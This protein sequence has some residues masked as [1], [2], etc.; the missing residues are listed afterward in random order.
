MS[1]YRQVWLSILSSMLLALIASLFV[2]LYNGRTYL[3]TQL[4]LKNRDNAAALALA[5]GQEYTTPDDLV[6]AITAQFNSGQY[7]YLLI[8]DPQGRSLVE[9]ITPTAEPGVPHWFVH[10]LPI[11]P[12]PGVAQISSGWRQVGTLSLMSHAH[13]AYRDLWSGATT[14]C[15][16]MLLAGILGGTLGSLALRRLRKPIR[17]VIDQARAIRERRFTTIPEPALPELRELAAAMNDMV[18][19]LHQELQEDAQRYEVMRRAANFDQLTGLANRAF[20]MANLART[21]ADEDSAGGSLAIIRMAH[22]AHIN[23]RFGREAADTLLVRVSQTLGAM[24]SECA[25]VFAARL[26]G[27]DFALLLA[28]E[29]DP[30]SVLDILRDRLDELAEPYSERMTSCYIGFAAFQQGEAMADLLARIDQAVAA[31]ESAGHGA[32]CEASPSGQVATPITTEAWRTSIR[33]VLAHA[34]H[35]ALTCHP[36]VLDDVPQHECRLRIRLA[37]SAEWLPTNRFM[38]QAE[39]LGMAPDLDLAAVSLALD[40]LEREPDAPPRWI[41]LSPRSVADIGFRGRLMEMLMLRRTCL[42][43]LWLEV[44]EIGA[45][46]HLDSLRE[47]VRGLQSLDCHLGL[48]HYGHQFS[49]IGDFYDLGLDFIKVDA[50][51]VRDIQSHPGNQAFLTGL[52]DTVHKIGMRVLAEGVQSQ[53]EL[54]A[55]KRLGMD[56]FTGP[57]LGESPQ[58]G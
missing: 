15:A 41:N 24:G 45:L 5:L 25:D 44:R 47:L 38:P 19:R 27:A 35:L 57:F 54:D 51:F 1:L 10:L 42:R 33:H 28:S 50:G 16:V 20:F 2:T 7:E 48:S 8:T 9:R 13:F 52:V 31:A 39:R 23:R 56:G 29:C 36:L 30:R 49:R 11:R 6:V 53:T 17:A 37:G 3:E 4:S 40:G 55:L 58:G 21:L 43:R 46:Q 12:T 26:K 34:D 14:L 18:T 32:V 22:L